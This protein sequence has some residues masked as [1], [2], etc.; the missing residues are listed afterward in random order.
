MGEQLTDGIF[1][2]DFD[3]DRLREYRR[4]KMTGVIEI[5]IAW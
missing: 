3:I 5:T 2:T 1:I 4:C